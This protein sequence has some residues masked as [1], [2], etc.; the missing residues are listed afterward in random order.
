MSTADTTAL[1]ADTPCSKA[2]FFH[3]NLRWNTRG[4]LNPDTE[5]L[6]WKGNNSPSR[7][8]GPDGP[9][10]LL[11]KQTLTDHLVHIVVQVP[12]DDP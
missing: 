4:G 6:H 7:E 3:A 5:D 9:A 2:M 12:V 11:L 1:V 8:T 10:P